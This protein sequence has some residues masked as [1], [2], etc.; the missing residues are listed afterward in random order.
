M[1]ITCINL[2]LHS[3]VVL[4][5]K[6]PD[7]DSCHGC[8]DKQSD[9]DSQYHSSLL[10][11]CHLLFVIQEGDLLKPPVLPLGRQR[12]TDIKREIS[13]FLTY[14]YMMRLLILEM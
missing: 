11:R 12:Q 9:E 14:I 13:S 10:L 2:R 5:N 6:E 4:T 7:E 1:I 3:K 8:Q